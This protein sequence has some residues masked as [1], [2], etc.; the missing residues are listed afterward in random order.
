[1]PPIDPVKARQFAIRTVSQLRDAG[2]EA[3]WAGGC[4]RDMLMDREPKDYDVATSA[5][6][7]Q[8]REVFGLR[9]T[10]AIGASFGVIAVLG[11]HGAG[12]IDVATFRRDAHYSDGRHPDS[13]TFCSAEEDAQRRDFTING[14]FYDPMNLRVIDYVGGQQDLAGGLIRAIGDPAARFQEDRL[15]VLRA[16]RFATTLNFQVDAQTLRAVQQFADQIRVVSAERITEEMRRTLVDPRR[17]RGLELLRT[18]GL[19]HEILP[20]ASGVIP[21][22]DPS[23]QVADIQWQR[24]LQIA[25]R[26][27]TTSFA[28]AMAV[29]LR[30]IYCS[31]DRRSS[32][33]ESVGRQW[34]ISNDDIQGIIFCLQQES[35]I[36]TA[37]T[38][39]WPKLQRVLTD[40][41]IE[42][43]LS[44]AEAVASI[45]DGNVAAIEFCRERL[46]WAPE[47]LDPGPL[48]SGYDLGAVGIPRGPIYKQLLEGVREAQLLGELT[49]KEQALD[50]IRAQWAARSSE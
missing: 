32:D 39:H 34:R 50:W 23:D 16:V 31:Q 46:R 36:R 9:H 35:M 15:R 4:V 41:R 19:L 17:R 13:V 8:I 6:P 12:Q 25:E 3:L 27:Q 38:I 22:N 45:V 29:L 43:L 18:T 42:L 5:H 20:Q 11:P 1:M 30:E 14:L 48:V 40:E 47:K 49:N 2:Y 21:R 10:L 7:D 44:Y 26:L 33:L 24:T 37:P 28:A